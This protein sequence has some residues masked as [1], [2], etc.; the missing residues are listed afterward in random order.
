MT[1]AEN[2]FIIHLVYSKENP[3]KFLKRVMSIVK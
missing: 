2:N 1:N 3:V